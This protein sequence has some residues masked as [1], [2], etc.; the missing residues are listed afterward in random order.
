MKILHLLAA[1][2]FI[3]VAGN[4][5]AN[6]ISNGGFESGLAGW[7]CTHVSGDCLTG[8]QTISAPEGSSYFFGYSNGGTGHLSQGFTSIAGAIYSISLVFDTNDQTS[9]NT[10]SLDVGNLS[11]DFLLLPFT[12]WTP[13][14]SNFIADSAFTTVDFS[15][16]TVG[17]TGTVWIDNVIV[18]LALIPN[19]VPVPA[20]LVLI[21]LGLAGLVLSRRK[22]A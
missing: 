2:L 5:H 11:T 12:T 21:A 13:F 19:P 1:G 17:G 6:L 16:S 7:S 20:P 9:T 10:L 18:E 3:L 4:S 15:F 22:T 14:T 8:T